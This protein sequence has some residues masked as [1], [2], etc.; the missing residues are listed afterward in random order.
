M[1]KEGDRTFVA[2]LVGVMVE[3]LV[4]RFAGLQR[5]E[6]QHQADQQNSQG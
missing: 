1:G 6:Q 5:I 4:Q 2:G 3:Q